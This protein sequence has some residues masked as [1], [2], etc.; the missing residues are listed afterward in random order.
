MQYTPFGQTGRMLSFLGIQPHRGPY[1]TRTLY[2][3][4]EQGIN[5][6][7]IDLMELGS[8]EIRELHD[9]LSDISRSGHP[10]YVGT[11]LGG[12]SGLSFRREAEKFLSVLGRDV[13][14]FCHIGP[15]RGR[16]GWQDSGW[17]RIFNTA[18]G[19]QDDGYIRH[20]C[21]RA[22]AEDEAVIEAAQ[23]VQSMIDGLVLQHQS[24]TF[25]FH[26][27]SSRWIRQSGKGVMVRNS[28]A[29]G[30][31]ERPRREY[32]FLKAFPS[33]S[34][35]EASIHFLMSCEHMSLVLTQFEN[36]EQVDRAVS[37]VDEFTGYSYDQFQ[38]IIDGVEAEIQRA[39]EDETAATMPGIMGTE[40]S[41]FPVFRLLGAIGSFLQSQRESLV[42]RSRFRWG[43]FSDELR[44]DPAQNERDE[45]TEG[46]NRSD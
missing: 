12:R 40:E 22:E 26:E 8:R 20:L 29:A 41:D 1:M 31:R 24:L 7:D 23:T 19:G 3:A 18:Y 27:R 9:L 14:D 6:I 30:M 34:L 46:E 16:E 39:G 35:L 13:I 33:Q 15:F 4:F 45:R 42:D 17:D 10:L 36:P 37:A 44:D 5:Y 25:P 28:F 38:E 11:T 2:R 32:S 21:L 43:R